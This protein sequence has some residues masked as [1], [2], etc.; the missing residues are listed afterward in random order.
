MPFMSEYGLSAAEG[1]GDPPA[2][3]LEAFASSMPSRYAVLFDP[4]SIRRHGAVAYRRGGK[5]AHAELWRSLPDAAA[6]CVVAEDRPGLLSAIAAALVSHRLDVITALV[7]SR[8][9]AS[10]ERE[11]VDLLWIRRATPSDTAA[12]GPEEA[13]SIGEVLSAILAGSISI[14][15][16]ASRTPK[17]AQPDDDVVVRF[18]EVDEDGQAVLLVEAA[19]RPGILLTIAFEVFQQGAQIVRS[20]VRTA[21]SRAFNRFVLA[22][23]SGAPLSPD[24][25]AQIRAAVFA[26]LAL[27]DAAREGSPG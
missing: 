9:T 10:G 12:I 25:R 6:L 8:V 11:A 22:E 21:D 15:E 18:E 16:I 23:F 26:A 17:S 3:Y 27:R 5:P 2:G 19:D 4:R 13:V 1:A 20:L 7:F 24:R 14:E